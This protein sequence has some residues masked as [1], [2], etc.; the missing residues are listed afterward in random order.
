MFLPRRTALL[1][2]V[3]SVALAGCE[4]VGFPLAPKEPA[5][6]AAPPAEE[7]VLRP[8]RRPEGEEQKKAPAVVG[9]TAAAMMGGSEGEV[10]NLLGQPLAVRNEPPSMVWHYASAGCKLDVFF[11]FDIG[12]KDFRALAYKFYPDQASADAERT[13]IAGIRDGKT[14]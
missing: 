12:N 3:M 7:A 14:R 8:P 2:A 13:C 11:Y 1:G 10:T 5:P 9:P 6:E 4:G